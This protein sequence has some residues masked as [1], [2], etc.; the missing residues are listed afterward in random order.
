MDR[1]ISTGYQSYTKSYRHPMKAG[2]KR[3]RLPLAGVQLVVQYQCVCLENILPSNIIQ[4]EHDIF[5]NIYTCT[6]RLVI[7]SNERE[8]MN[9]KENM[10][11]LWEGLDGEKGK[12]ISCNCI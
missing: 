8:C 12:D 11:G 7:T 2:E 6:C 9:L 4:T 3:S 5:R 10:V 1:E